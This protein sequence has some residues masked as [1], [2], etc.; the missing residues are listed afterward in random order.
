[1][2]IHIVGGKLQGVEAAYLARKAGWKTSLLDKKNAELL[3][4]SSLVDSF[5]QVDV[6]DTGSLDNHAKNGELFIP[7]MENP[8]TL[9]GLKRWCCDNKVP[10]A[11]DPSA[12]AL[13]SSKVESNRL[14]SRLGIS[15]PK[16]WPECG[17][18]LLVKPGSASGSKGVRVFYDADELKDKLAALL[19][20]S[21]R[22]VS[23]PP[24]GWVFQEYLEGPSFSIEVVGTP[25]N[26]K[27]LQV[28]DLEMDAGYDCKRVLAPT[29]LTPAQAGRFRAVA[30]KIAEAI[31]LRGLMDVEA[32]H[33]EG[34]LKILEIDARLPSQ[35][36][37]VVY[38]STG[39]NILELW[40]QCFVKKKFDTPLPGEK[41]KG[42]VYEHIKVENGHIETL[43]EH[44]MA[45]ADALH[46]HNDFFGADEALTNY[47]PGKK[48]W[49]ATLIVVGATREA[50]RERRNETIEKIKNSL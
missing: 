32:I 34:R 48:S 40:A 24:E 15:M 41:G 14:F 38:H 49:V 31:K 3:P 47:S 26:Y 11:Y 45:Q 20:S 44:I 6:L 8:G 27:A 43:G 17:F 19:D 5:S 2:L 16:P 22:F 46:L 42:V 12:Y 7:A 4:A 18:P 29:Q 37:T 10:L 33:H 21:E 25:G 28:T 23:I 9:R 13:S 30:V 36:P 39:C 35:T 50:A 1:M